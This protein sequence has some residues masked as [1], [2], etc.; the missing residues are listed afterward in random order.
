MLTRRIRAWT[1]LAFVAI[2]A[3]LAAGTACDLNPQPLPPGVAAPSS[4]FAPSDAGATEPVVFGGSDAGGGDLSSEGGPTGAGETDGGDAG[5]L[6]G[7]DAS[8]DAGDGGDAGMADAS[9]DAHEDAE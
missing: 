1:C 6:S 9:T 7:G 2:S 3:A 4:G 5:A 8:V